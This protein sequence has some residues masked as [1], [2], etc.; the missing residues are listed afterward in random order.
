MGG[1]FGHAQAHALMKKTVMMLA[2]RGRAAADPVGLDVMTP[3][4][5]G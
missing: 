1:G 4:Y 2:Q 3:A 5:A